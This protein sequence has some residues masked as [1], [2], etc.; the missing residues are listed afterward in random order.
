M[1]KMQEN[2]TLGR[3][4]PPKYRGPRRR[5]PAFSTRNPREPHW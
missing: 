5:T 4:P 3:P 2:R 1:S